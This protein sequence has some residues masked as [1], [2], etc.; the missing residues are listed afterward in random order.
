MRNLGWS[1]AK[2]WCWCPQL[3]SQKKNFFTSSRA[4]RNIAVSASSWHCCTLITFLLKVSA[5]SRMSWAVLLVLARNFSRWMRLLMSG[6]IEMSQNPFLVR[7]RWSW[8]LINRIVASI[9][10]HS[11]LETLTLKKTGG[12]SRQYPSKW[13]KPPTRRCVGASH[14]LGPLQCCW[15]LL[16]RIIGSQTTSGQ[17]H[18]LHHDRNYTHA[19]CQ[20]LGGLNRGRFR[21]GSAHRCGFRP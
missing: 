1:A 17:V 18:G 12:S 19:R 5:S 4:A 3:S 8:S 7:L 15:I 6:W 11:D 20:V 9:K 16:R 14:H 13:D 21:N 2:P 10:E